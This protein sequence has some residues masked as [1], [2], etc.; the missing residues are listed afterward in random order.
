VSALSATWLEARLAAPA[1]ALGVSVPPDAYGPLAAYA[2]LVLDWGAR[3]NLTGA[4]T[5]EALADDHLADALALLGHLP[6]RP[7]AFVDVGSGAGLPGIVIALLR[8]DATGTLLEPVA[9]KHAFLAH[10]VRSLGLGR[11]VAARAGRLEPHLEAGGRGAYDVAVSRAVWPASDW[12]LRGLPLLAQGGV[13]LG[14][15][16]ASPGDVPPGCERHPYTL[17]RDRRRSL[18]VRRL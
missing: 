3:I 14:L 18:L 9:K 10:A 6:P 15:E 7:F 2:A 8:P 1:R 12:V 4:R 5:P 17:G 16:G 11:R 13:L